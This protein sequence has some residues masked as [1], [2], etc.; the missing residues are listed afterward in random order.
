[1]SLL[2][3]IEQ[4]KNASGGAKGCIGYCMG[5]T[6]IL[7]V[8]GKLPNHFRAGSSLFGVGMVTEDPGSPHHFL[9][10]STGEIYFGLGDLDEYTPPK[11]VEML[12]AVLDQ[13]KISYEIEYNRGARHGFVFAERPPAY[14]KEAAE[15]SWER[16]FSLFRRNLST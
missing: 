8:M 15:R 7:G 11:T 9:N 2:S 13:K 10:S 14:N 3:Y 12:R 4:D 16:S 6:L 1:M 5:G